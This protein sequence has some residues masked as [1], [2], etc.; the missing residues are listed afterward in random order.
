MKKTSKTAKVQIAHYA[1]TAF[2][3]YEQTANPNS[4]LPMVLRIEETQR[5]DINAR[6]VLRGQLSEQQPSFFTGIL[7]LYP[8]VY[9]GNIQSFSN[10]K[11][12]RSLLVLTLSPDAEN[13]TVHLFPGRMPKQRTAFIQ[14]YLKTIGYGGN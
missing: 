3:N 11:K 13:M 8:V 5:P 9:H 4:N 1:K 2:R 12:I 6:Y 10:R 14:D 7:L